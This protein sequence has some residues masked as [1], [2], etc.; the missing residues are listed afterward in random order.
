MTDPFIDPRP[1][2]APEGRDSRRIP[3]RGGLWLLLGLI[4]TGAAWY[5][6]YYVKQP[7]EAPVPQQSARPGGARKGGFDPNRAMPVIAVP[8][9]TADVPVFLAGLGSVTPLATVTVRTRID[10]QLMKVLFREGQIVRSGELLAEID[11]RTYEAQ[12]AQAEGQMAKDQALLRNAR[13]DLERYRTLFQQDSIARQQL[14]TQESLVRQF[15]ATAKV[16]QA[17]IDTAKL[18]IFYTRITAPISGRLG[19][20]QVDAGNMVRSGDAG[21][22]V[23]ITQL[24]PISVVFS[25]PEDHVRAVMTKLRG[26]EKLPVE[27]WDR[28]EKNRLA[29]GT[30]L[31]VDNQ[32]DSA[33]GT[34]KLKAGFDNRDF[35]LFPNQFVNTR[36][37]LEVRRGATVVPSAA[38]QRG[39]QGTFVYVVKNDSTVTIRPVSLGPVHGENVAIEK[40]LAPGEVVVTD[41]ADKLRE[42][43]KVDAGARNAAAGGTDSR[44][45]GRGEGRREGRG[46]TGKGESGQGGARKSAEGDGPRRGDAGA[47]RR[48]DRGAP[49]AP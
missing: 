31:T 49:P 19:L 23:V 38:V 15:E 11:P 37:R 26:G 45:S 16:D 21:G 42:G 8:A 28:A 7:A 33:T 48:G 18:Q 14:D 36:M 27:A 20:R 35:S 39:S 17:A 40:G 43:G 41:G 47:T 1:G 2:V 4:A 22:I 34:V 9:K 13:L 30:L 46:E 32:I 29:S 24:E 44:N 25:L 10:G 12:L 5:Y 3:R 6:L